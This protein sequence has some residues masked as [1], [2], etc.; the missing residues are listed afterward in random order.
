[1]CQKPMKKNMIKAS[2]LSGDLTEE[3]VFGDSMDMRQGWVVVETDG[4]MVADHHCHILAIFRD[5]GD[6]GCWKA[7][8]GL[9]DV[10]D[11]ME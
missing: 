5:L 1:M 3:Q 9:M 6:Q 2:I 11:L 10:L 7:H 4:M 8:V